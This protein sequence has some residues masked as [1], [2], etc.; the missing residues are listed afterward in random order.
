MKRGDFLGIFAE[1]L[2]ECRRNSK[3]R[4]QDVSESLE[5]G[6]STYCRYEQ[7][8]RLPCIDDAAKMAQLFHVSLDYLAGLTDDPTPPEGRSL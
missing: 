7:G 5:I 4:Q 6:Y 2:K 8:G 1:R 3:L